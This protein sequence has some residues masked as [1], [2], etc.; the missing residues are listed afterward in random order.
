MSKNILIADDEMEILELI[1]LY[2][3]K[4]GFNIIKAYDGQQALEEIKKGNVELAIID[5][6]MPKLNGFQLI[7]KIRKEYNIPLIILSAKGEFEDKILGLGLG[8]DDYITKPFNALE[9]TARVQAQLRRFYDLNE[10]KQTKETMLKVNEISLNRDS[11]ILHKND[12]EIDL[13]SVEYKI[14]ILLMEHVGQVF[15][16][17][18]IYENVWNEPYYGDDNVI[19]VHISKLRDKLEDNPKKPKYIKTIR[20]LG[21]KFNR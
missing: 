5:I 2:L 7:K 12:N 14:L 11:C 20:G 19:M 6:M 15:T 8:A 1:E 3:M 13:T 17:K 21:Y 4:D 16:K 18:Q 10:F 9:L